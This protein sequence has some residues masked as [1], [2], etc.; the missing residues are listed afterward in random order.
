MPRISLVEI[1]GG[2]RPCVICKEIKDKSEFSLYQYTTAYGNR[3]KRYSSKCKVCF[4]ELRKQRYKSPHGVKM[5]AISNAYKRKNKE[6][7]N[8]KRK[9]YIS[10]NRGKFL[11]GKRASEMRR[12]SENGDLPTEVIIRVLEE[13][14][15]G[16][17]YLDA[18]SG[19]WISN[20]TVDH[21]NPIFL[22]GTHEYEN[23]CVT[24]QSNNSSKHAKPLIYWLAVR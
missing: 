18:Y 5:R 1:H 9:E 10:K 3:S 6:A 2:K 20:P 11:A 14:R 15:I 7:L 16:D 19:E 4:N 8:A 12:R 24:S 17:K 22:G 13:A 21:I 23:L